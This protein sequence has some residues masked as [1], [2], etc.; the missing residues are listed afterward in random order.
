M[1]HSHSLSNRGTQTSKEG[2]G[3]QAGLC[4]QS[5]GFRAQDE[6]GAEEKAR[7]LTLFNQ[8]SIFTLRPEAIS[9]T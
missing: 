5:A 3:D 6:A 7:S 1:G 9:R 2:S 8:G 4:E